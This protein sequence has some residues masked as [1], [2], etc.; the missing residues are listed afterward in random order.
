MDP[1]MVESIV[2]VEQLFKKIKNTR[3]TSPIGG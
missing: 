3:A 1:I 2:V